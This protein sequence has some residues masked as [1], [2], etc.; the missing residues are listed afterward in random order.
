ML[1]AAAAIVA[2]APR[3][4]PLP[5]KTWWELG[6]LYRAPPRPFG[7][8]LKGVEARLDHVTGLQMRG[9]VLGP[10]HPQSPGDPQNLPLDQLDPTLGTLQDFSQLLQTAKKKGLQVI[11]D[12]TPNYLG[13][14]AWMGQA[15]AGDPS[16]QQKVKRALSVWLERGVSG[17]FLDGIEELE[18]SVVAEW[19]NLTEQQDPPDGVP[20]VLMGG[21]RLRAPG[22]C[23]RC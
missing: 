17:F 18:P 23:R 9:L 11:L 7:G 22:R 13:G 2:R 19:R 3:C 20:R 14:D 1:G 10:L 4:R 8:N 12:L 5:P 6:G 21:T 15:V 16:F